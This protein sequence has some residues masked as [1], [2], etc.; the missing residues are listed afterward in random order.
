[1]QKK[2]KWLAIC[3][4]IPVVLTDVS[5][6]Q[7]AIVVPPRGHFDLKLTFNVNGLKIA[8]QRYFVQGISLNEILKCG[9]GLGGKGVSDYDGLR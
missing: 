5:D 2:K 3:G 7:F 1:M 4:T 8:W 9:G 6:Y